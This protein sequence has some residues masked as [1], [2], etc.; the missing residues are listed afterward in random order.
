MSSEAAE[1]KF[2]AILLLFLVPALGGALFGYDIG[3]TAFVIQ[4][5]QSQKYSGIPWYDTVASSPILIGTIVAISAIGAFSSSWFVFQL[6]DSIGRRQELRIGAILYIIGASIAS[7]SGGIVINM[8]G[9]TAA[10]VF[11]VFGRFIFGCGIGFT[12]H[13][14]SIYCHFEFVLP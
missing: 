12:M 14:V 3:A 11:L 10:I 5:L 7:L 2:T 8:L 1:F 4:Q 6:N 9:S 13:G